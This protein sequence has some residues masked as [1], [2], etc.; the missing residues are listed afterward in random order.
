MEGLLNLNFGTV[1]QASDNNTWIDQLLSLF[2]F[3]NH[4]RHL[5][6][7]VASGTVLVT[8]GT[9]RMVKTHE[10]ESPQQVY[11]ETSTTLW[12]WGLFF[13]VTN[14]FLPREVWV[15]RTAWFLK[16]KNEACRA[17]EH[18]GSQEYHVLIT[19]PTRHLLAC[20]TS[21]GLS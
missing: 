9:G 19:P 1:F 14:G 7:D 12:I 4:C 10:Y 6:G 21:P 11:P 18:R 13:T 3:L 8:L 16:H 5:R 2:R 15:G 20:T 17:L